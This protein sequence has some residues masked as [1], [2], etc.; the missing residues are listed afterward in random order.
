[1][2]MPARSSTLVVAGIGPVSIITGSTPASAKVW[3]RARG[4]R[5]SSFA[6]SSLMI[7]QRRRAVGDLDRVRRGDHAVGLERGLQ[8]GRASPSTSRGGC[9]RRSRHQLGAVLAVH[10]D[11]DDLPVEPALGGRRRGALVRLTEKR[12]LSSRL[13]FHFSAISSAE[14]PCGHEVRVA[15]EHLRPERH[16]ARHERRA[17]RHPA[18][19]L[20]AR[21]DHDVVRAGHHALGRE[22][23]GLLGGSALAVDRWC[24][25]CSR[26]SRRRARRCARR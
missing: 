20:D 10:L 21:G 4:V 23:R 19:V 6:F 26:G 22:V 3:K 15:L 25:P 2:V 13:M 7:E 8:L 17:H 5:P 18:H 16:A 9:P 14:M 24:R 1:M 12:S 11:R